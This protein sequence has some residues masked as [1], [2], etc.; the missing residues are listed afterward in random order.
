[1]KNKEEKF[2]S[3]IKIENKG[4][5]FDPFENEVPIKTRSNYIKDAVEI[6]VTVVEILSDGKEKISEKE[7]AIVNKVLGDMYDDHARVLRK[8]GKNYDESIRPTLGEFYNRLKSMDYEEIVNL[9]PI[10]E[11]YIKDMDN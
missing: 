1:M 2:G 4:D 5:T 11:K 9:I 7:L 10:F 6:I 3:L 8:S